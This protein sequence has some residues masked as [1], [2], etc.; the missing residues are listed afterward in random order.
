IGRLGDARALFEQATALAEELLARNEHWPQVQLLL[1]GIWS[2]R[3]EVAGDLGPPAE[4]SR[5]RDEGLRQARSA[6]R[7]LPPLPALRGQHPLLASARFRIAEGL[8]K[9]EDHAGAAS[10]MEG[11]PELAA[12]DPTILEASARLWISCLRSLRRDGDSDDEAR[13]A[14]R[15]RYTAGVIQC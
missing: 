7:L 10:A 3:A 15:A 2:D 8:L 14:A 6:E 12:G 9:A 13:E 1:A 11:V 4:L 5:C